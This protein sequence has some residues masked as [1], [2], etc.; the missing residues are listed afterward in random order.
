MIQFVGV[1]STL[2]FITCWKNNLPWHMHEKL[3]LFL[4]AT[5]MI[6]DFSHMLTSFRCTHGH[7]F[8]QNKIV[9]MPGLYTHVYTE[10]Y[11]N[12]PWCF[13][14]DALCLGKPDPCASS[15]CLNGGT[16][17]HYIGKYKCE[18]SPSFIGRHCEINRGSNPALE[19]NQTLFYPQSTASCLPTWI[20]SSHGS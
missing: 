5:V 17:F 18:C 8:F 7:A 10:L 9:Q 4:S 2:G 11:T 20:G 12:C 1:C 16:C 6:R 19:G 14:S 13:K 3:F 15:P